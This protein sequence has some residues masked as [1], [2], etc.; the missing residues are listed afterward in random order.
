[1]SRKNTAIVVILLVLLGLVVWVNTRPGATLEATAVR[2][3]GGP[4]NFAFSQ[5]LLIQELR[6][7]RLD[8][9]GGEAL[10]PVWHLVRR[11][12]DPDASGEIP[13]R[14]WVAAVTYG[15]RPPGMRRSPD[16]DLPND[17][18]QLETGQPYR[19]TILAKPDNVTLEF[20][21]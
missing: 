16:T 17:G 6:V 18:R 20:T 5:D 7:D 21:P 14:W 13:E 19:L 8:T 11:E 1:M 4:V 15:R 10:E 9:P 2:L 3:G 12:L